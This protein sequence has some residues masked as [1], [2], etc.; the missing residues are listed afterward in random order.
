MRRGRHAPHI[1]A[2]IALPKDLTLLAQAPRERKKNRHP[3]PDGRQ[4][5]NSATAAAPEPMAP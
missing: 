1:P 4:E 5:L 2:S 3:W